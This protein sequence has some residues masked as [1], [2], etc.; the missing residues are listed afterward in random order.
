MKR[1]KK[2]MHT[3]FFPHVAVAAVC[4]V[5]A[6]A[7]LIYTFAF[8]EEEGPFAYISYVF[9][10]YA[11]A[12]SCLG[13]FPAV[14]GIR[15][16]AAEFANGNPHVNRFMSDI[17]FKTKVTLALSL[18]VN[19]GYAALKLI[20][21]IYYRS[22]WL[23][24]LAAYYILL[25]VI[26]LL[27]LSHIG[28]DKSDRAAE[29]RR[30]RACGIVLIFINIVLAGMIVRVLRHGDGFTYSGNLIYVMA[31]YDF[32]TMIMAIV[33]LVK[34]RKRGS[35][36]LTAAK[37]VNFAA[38]LITMLSLETAMLAQFGGDEDFAFRYNIVSYTGG[39]ICAILAFIAVFMIAGA[40][41]GL[42]A[43]R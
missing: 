42:K 11:L 1:V 35:P 8:S 24:T 28:K 2:V 32:Y 19:T 14:R 29:L 34:I 38:A 26:R 9:S 25:L 7:M 4:A 10:A 17:T 37:A 23:I 16:R 6:A 27:L 21:G 41:A 20:T 43:N 3:L 13:V 36:I 12:V 5:L 40:T 22:A 18:A 30:C 39:G 31:M 15:R 33:N